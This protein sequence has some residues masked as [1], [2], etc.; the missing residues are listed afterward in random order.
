MA[1]DKFVDIFVEKVNSTDMEI[2]VITVGKTSKKIFIG[3]SIAVT[4]K[5]PWPFFTR[6]GK[7]CQVLP[8]VGGV[9]FYEIDEAR[10]SQSM[11]ARSKNRTE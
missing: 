9:K 2:I 4:L 6:M 5:V 10:T 1:G 11:S 7:G 3:V 8:P